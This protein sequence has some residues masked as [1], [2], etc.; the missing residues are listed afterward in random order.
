MGQFH[1]KVDFWKVYFLTVDGNS[2]KLGG[3]SSW[4]LHMY[5]Y[6]IYIYLYIYIH[7]VFSLDGVWFSRLWSC[8][9]DR[10]SSGSWRRGSIQSSLMLHPL[11]REVTLRS[12]EVSSW[13]LCFSG[14]KVPP[15]FFFGWLD[16]RNLSIY[17]LCMYIYI[18]IWYMYINMLHCIYIYNFNSMS[19]RWGWFGPQLL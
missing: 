1:G 15:W 17:V 11:A 18:D 4:C 5:I 6:I 19:F 7:I 14:F 3:S 12:H 9:G 2:K 16:L 8:F 10:I 13:S